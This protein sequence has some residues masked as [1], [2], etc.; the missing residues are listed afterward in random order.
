MEHTFNTRCVSGTLWY[1]IRKLNIFLKI[2]ILMVGWNLLVMFWGLLLDFHAYTIQK[3]EAQGNEVRYIV[4][5]HTGIAYDVQLDLV[6]KGHERRGYPTSE[7]VNPKT[8]TGYHI[9]YH[10]FIGRDA[11]V[12]K[13]R[14][15]WER[16]A[17]TRADR[18]NFYSIGIVLAGDFNTQ[19]PTREQVKEFKA[20]VKRLQKRY[21]DSRLIPH[22]DASKTSCPGKNMR[23]ILEEMGV[24]GEVETYQVSRYYTPVPGQQRYYRDSYEADFKVNC[25]G[26]CLVTADGYRMSPEDAGKVVACPPDLPFGTRLWVQSIGEVVCHDHGSAINGKRLDLWAG[27]GMD[28]LNAI[29]TNSIPAG[30]LRV[31]VI[32]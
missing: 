3:A 5:H 30:T 11:T 18:I 31:K 23:P 14:Q 19:E 7:I 24:P 4:A 32:P 9:A 10:Y 25:S 6:E 29:L 8:G 28:G 15:E 22:E 20:L 16:T 21:P 13:L 12:I 1:Q 27:Q 26:D 2:A 17:H